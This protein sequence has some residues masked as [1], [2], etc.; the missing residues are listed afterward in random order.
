[1][2]DTDDLLLYDD[3]FEHEKVVESELDRIKRMRSEL[4]VLLN[5]SEL[6][7]YCTEKLPITP[8]WANCK[9]GQKDIIKTKFD[10]FVEGHVQPTSKSH[11]YH[12]VDCQSDGKKM[13]AD[14]LPPRKAPI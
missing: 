13:V 7:S 4:S 10:E 14:C 11:V 6:Y 2:T 8:T 1:M 5:G 9:R 12:A 3:D